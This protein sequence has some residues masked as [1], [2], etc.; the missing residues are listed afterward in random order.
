MK[1]H[2]FD[3]GQTGMSTECNQLVV[4]ED[5]EE[6]GLPRWHPDHSAWLQEI[7]RRCIP[8]L[9]VCIHGVGLMP[10]LWCGGCL[11]EAWRRHYSGTSETPCVGEG[12]GVLGPCDEH[13]SP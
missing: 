4:R 13:R 8:G 11:A 7:S 10:G 3:P 1:T 5:T 12:C 2:E 6:C 9:E